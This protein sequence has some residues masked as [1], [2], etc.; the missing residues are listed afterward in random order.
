MTTQGKHAQPTRDFSGEIKEYQTLAD[1]LSAAEAFIGARVWEYRDRDN[2][3]F[4]DLDLPSEEYELHLSLLRDALST[5][6]FIPQ[7]TENLYEQIPLV[8]LSSLVHHAL[9]SETTDFWPS[10]FASLKVAN[11]EFLRGLI[12]RDLEALLDRKKLENFKNT[13]LANRYVNKIRLHAGIPAL[14]LPPLIDRI[15][16]DRRHDASLTIEDADEYAKRLVKELQEAKGKASRLQTIRTLALALPERMS[17]LIARLFEFVVDIESLDEPPSVEDLKG[18]QFLPELMLRQALSHLSGGAGADETDSGSLSFELPEP[19]LFLDPESLELKV[20]IPA[21]QESTYPDSEA[22]WTIVVDG[23][24]QVFEQ[25]RDWA[26]GGWAELECVLTHPYREL[27]VIGPGNT[28][29]KMESAALTKRDYLLFR[30]DGW[31]YANQNT[32]SKA[33]T[34]LLSPAGTNVQL[35]G[36]GRVNRRGQ[37]AGWPRWVVRA[38][39]AGD[40]GR[41]SI[42]FGRTKANLEVKVSREA[43]FDVEKAVIPWVFSSDS[44]PV[45]SASPTVWIPEG[46]ESWVLCYYQLFNNERILLD[47]YPVEDSLK[48]T[49]FDVFDRANDPWVGRYEV[50]VFRDG[51]HQSTNTFNMAEDLTVELS[52]ENWAQRGHFRSPDPK[53]KS[54]SLTKATA[55][56]GENGGRRLAIG[57]NSVAISSSIQSQTVRV[58]SAYDRQQYFLDVVIRPPAMSYSIPEKDARMKWYIEPVAFSFDDLDDIGEFQLKFPQ[59]VYDPQLSLVPMTGNKAHSP[60]AIALRKGSRANTW[61]LDVAQLKQQMKK[62]AT[63]ILAA[64]WYIS[65]YEEWARGRFPRATAASLRD[66]AY[67]DERN[68]AYSTVAQINKDPLLKAATVNDDNLKLSWGREIKKKVDLRVWSISDPLAPATS[69]VASGDSVELPE[70]LCDGSTL[71]VEAKEQEFLST[72]NPARPTKKAVIVNGLSPLFNPLAKQRGNRWLF[73][74]VQNHQLMGS[75][76]ST[77]WQIRD[78]FHAVLD[79]ASTNETNGLGALAQTTKTYLENNP[80]VSVNTL[81]ESAIEESRQ[82]SAY[83]RANLADKS[84]SVWATAGDIHPVPWI[85]LLQ[86]MSDVR[87]LTSRLKTE[88]AREELQESLDFIKEVGGDFV[89]KTMNGVDTPFTLIDRCF[90]TDDLLKVFRAQGIK[91]VLDAL[92]AANAEEQHALVS[93]ENYSN[94]LMQLMNNTVRLNQIE[95]LPHAW[96]W[97]RS[98]EHLIDYLRNRDL[99]KAV[100]TLADL[101]ASHRENA[102]DNWM[103]VPYVSFVS[104]LLAR[105]EANQILR[106]IPGGESARDAWSAVAEVAPKLAAIDIV[107]AEAFVLGHKQQ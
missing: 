28:V 65:S 4:I 100:S 48:G 87:V 53:A 58:A 85:G 7:N 80:R 55:A 67:K 52:Y 61:V 14:E 43:I 66:R 27:L 77:V 60:T 78:R 73:A 93:T 20:I 107:L 34:L 95:A 69:L 44:R 101:P 11:P 42:D 2:T 39:A 12:Q 62:A 90:I 13:E 94:A 49:A 72:W 35:T 8:F 15:Q 46:K 68:P 84:L 29:F 86:E 40:T 32:L 16:A 47:E 91:A 59:T 82:L 56:F 5:E 64:Q 41:L 106:P 102:E 81:S 19:K 54:F 26:T 36:K 22:V 45:L 3:L 88:A 17:G 9:T 104:A 50:Q 76:M 51:K 1:R 37:V 99:L 96:E 30:A 33:E 105:A 89:F 83:I 10:Y 70:D 57:K 63:Y 23:A 79:S 38:I 71:I 103:Y 74:P 25:E 75:E 24:R 92:R 31:L 98:H 21:T 18:M 6:Q 97:L